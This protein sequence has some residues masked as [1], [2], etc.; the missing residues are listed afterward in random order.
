MIRNWWR[1]APKFQIQFS[2]H[3][4][5]LHQEICQ[6]SVHPSRVDF[7]CFVILL[8]FGVRMHFAKH[9]KYAHTKYA[10]DSFLGAKASLSPS[11]RSMPSIRS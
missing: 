4:E 11:I 7:C 6:D 5:R 9:T 10:N 3:I 2:K 8:Y 1:Q